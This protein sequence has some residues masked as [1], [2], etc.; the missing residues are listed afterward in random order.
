MVADKVRYVAAALA[1]ITAILYFLI[2]AH[3]LPVVE[4]MDRGVTVFGLIA[5]V[6]FCLITIALVLWKRRFVWIAVAV[7]QVFAIAMY[8]VVGRD[9]VPHYEIWGLLIRI[10]QVLIIGTT[11]YLALRATPARSRPA[12]ASAQ[13]R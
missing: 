3:V 9:R 7:L 12:E 13:R 6:G 8:F 5:G 2:A 10:P 4:D 11:A 1:G